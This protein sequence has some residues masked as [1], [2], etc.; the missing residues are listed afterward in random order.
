MEKAAEI[1]RT[2]AH[3][4]RLQIIDLLEGG[5]KTVSELSQNL[6]TP[7]PYMSQQ[8]NLMKSKSIL[9]SRR[10][11]NQVYYWIANLSV[12]KIIHCINQHG[13]EGGI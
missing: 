13:E 4:V 11:G 12:V 5:E 2:M 8:L 7:Q 10:D 1:L 6:D 3:P 9:G